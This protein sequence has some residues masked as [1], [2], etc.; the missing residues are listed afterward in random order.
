MVADDHTARVEA[1]AEEAVVLT[2]KALTTSGL[3]PSGQS[4]AVLQVVELR[5]IADALVNIE[6]HLD[7]LR[8]RL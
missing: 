7:K 1:I 5:R 3:I 2:R 8:G 4:F 6:V